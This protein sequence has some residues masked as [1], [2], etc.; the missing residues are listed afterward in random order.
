[1]QFLL[2]GGVSLGQIPAN[3]DPSWI[4]DRAWMQLHS[5]DA[6]LK[7]PVS[8]SFAG[9]SQL[10]KRY[11]YDR[12]VSISTPFPDPQLN[13]LSQFQRLLLFRTLA[14]EKVFFFLSFM[15]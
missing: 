8:S 6:L 12:D 9:N 1:M 10:W 11:F 7:I 5:L 15:F 3:P 4:V 13:G 14:P 2:T